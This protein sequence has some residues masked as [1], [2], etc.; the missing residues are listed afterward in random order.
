MVPSTSSEAP[1]T[2]S[3]RLNFSSEQLVDAAVGVVALVEE[4]DHHDV[5]LLS[6][7][8]AAADALLDALG[9]PGQ[10]VVDDQRAE[11]EVDA[12]RGGLG[13]DQDRRMIAK[14]LDE[15]GADVDGARTGRTTG[16]R[17]LAQA[18]ARRLRWLP[19]RR[20]CR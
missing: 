16:R 20:W 15:G 11:L 5:V 8:M 6:V 12:F 9:V 17:V 13:G 1:N 10:V 7:A 3:K 2:P 19:A 18:S 4:V 14:M